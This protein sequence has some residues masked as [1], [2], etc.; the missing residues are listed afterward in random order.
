MNTAQTIGTIRLL[1]V[2]Y[3]IEDDG[4]GGSMAVYSETDERGC[5]VPYGDE[6]IECETVDEAV[7]AL[8]D[9]GATEWLG[10]WWADPD[11]STD[12]DYVTAERS[13]RTAHPNGFSDADVAV[14][15]EALS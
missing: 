2:R 5:P 9:H 12:V 7:R 4:S 14:I 10:S 3:T 15:L 1:D 11:G 6:T 13:E 8:R